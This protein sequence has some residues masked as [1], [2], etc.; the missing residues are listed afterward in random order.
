MHVAAFLPS[1]QMTY[2]QK[3]SEPHIWV[4]YS[5]FPIWADHIKSLQRLVLGELFHWS[6]WEMQT[7]RN[8]NKVNWYS[9][10][11]LKCILQALCRDSFFFFCVCF[12]SYIQKKLN[13]CLPLEQVFLCLATLA[14]LVGRFF[15]FCCFQL[16]LL[17]EWR[18]SRRPEAGEMVLYIFSPGVSST[19]NGKGDG[20]WHSLEHPN[21][22]PAWPGTAGKET[23]PFHWWE[24]WLIMGRRAASNI[25]ILKSFLSLWSSCW[26]FK[27]K[28]SLA[29]LHL[30]PALYLSTLRWSLRG[31][32][33]RQS[34]VDGWCMYR[35]TKDH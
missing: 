5:S 20:S 18:N 13:Y 23:G 14:G 24:A 31:T 27:L 11:I 17:L 8:M 25:K 19:S 15:H 4:Y 35:H 2:T 26:R 10:D 34:S 16:S 29:H 32:V 6:I 30:D 22:L 3:Q 28:L 33:R 12:I 9:H 7:K 21:G 1:F